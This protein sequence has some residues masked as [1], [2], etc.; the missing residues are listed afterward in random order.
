M[1][2]FKN[3]GKPYFIRVSEFYN[4]GGPLCYCFASRLP[5]SVVRV[6]F[7]DLPDCRFPAFCAFQFRT[8]GR[9]FY[10]KGFRSFRE[11]SEKGRGKAK[12]K[13]DIPTFKLVELGEFAAVFPFPL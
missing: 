5:I 9:S 11:V 7:A 12:R 8:E 1:S 6:T 2:V 13:N 10:F 3:E 4:F